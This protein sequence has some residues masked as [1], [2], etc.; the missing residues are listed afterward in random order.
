MKIGDIGSE[1]ITREAPGQAERQCGIVRVSGLPIAFEVNE[2]CAKVEPG[3]RVLRVSLD[4]GP[5]LLQRSLSITVLI[6]VG[7]EQAVDLSLFLGRINVNENS[8]ER[9][10]A[11]IEVLV[12]DFPVGAA[13]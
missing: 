7:S 13:G 6:G 1:L 8:V 9:P 12:A 10:P 5:R 4:L 2:I 11:F 3:V